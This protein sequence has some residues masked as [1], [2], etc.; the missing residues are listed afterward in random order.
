MASVRAFVFKVIAG[1]A[2]LT[3]VAFAQSEADSLRDKI[4]TGQNPA[5]YRSS[6][7]SEVAK[8][9]DLNRFPTRYS[10][11]WAERAFERIRISPDLPEV[12]TRS[13][14]APSLG[15][16]TTIMWVVLA[17][18]VAAG[19]YFIFRNSTWGGLKRKK[20]AASGI[21][22]AEESRRSANDWLRLAD[23]FEAN[24]QF[25]EAMRALYLAS[26]T[27]LDRARILP[28]RP[29]ET[30]WEHCL[31][32]EQ[33][34]DARPLPVRSATATFDRVWYGEGVA[35]REMIGELRQFYAQ[36]AGDREGAR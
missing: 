19:L 9:Y 18:A 32:Y 7:K 25:R 17:A 35:T 28:L 11:R 8:N 3:S 14:S 22:S 16:V 15:V 20:A 4:F 24:G 36:C 12:R 26:L 13:A 5:D 29:W 10:N 21:M 6:A 34:V 1:A 33:L 2:L 31:R 23:E 27:S 30:N